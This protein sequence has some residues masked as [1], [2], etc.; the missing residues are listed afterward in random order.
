MVSSDRMRRL[1]V[2]LAALAFALGV[3]GLTVALLLVPPRQ[4]GSGGAVGGPFSLVTHEGKPVS[5]RDFAGRPY[6]VF[7]GFTH[8][9]DICPTT[10]FQMSEI[11]ARTGDKGRNLR[12]LFITVDPERDT[13]EVMRSYVSS[14]DDRI[15]GLTGDPASVETALRSFRGFARKVPT[16]DGD[17]TMEHTSF[18]Y[19]MGRDN[20]FIGTISLSGPPEQAARDLLAKL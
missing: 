11:L 16:K 15:I 2:P 4:S 8:C 6:L 14:F 13:P 19:L 1:A 20:S 5:E 3:L 9:P 17:Y 18:V 7:F 10:L 12:A